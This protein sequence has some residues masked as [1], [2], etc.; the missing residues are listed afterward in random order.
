MNTTV[1]GAII[2]I[3]TTAACFT[4]YSIAAKYKIW[5]LRFIPAGI[6]VLGTAVCVILYSGN[7]I[8]YDFTVQGYII[9]FGISFAVACSASLL[10]I[11]GIYV[12]ELWKKVYG[13]NNKQKH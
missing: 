5:A 7:F 13:K 3:I 12:K 11:G 6:C 2:I 4:A 8:G 1:M 10:T 9:V